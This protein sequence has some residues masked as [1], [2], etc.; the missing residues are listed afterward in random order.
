MGQEREERRPKLITPYF[1][2]HSEKAAY[3]ECVS[4]DI[5]IVSDYTRLNFMQI[6]D[7]EVFDYYGYLHD[8]VVWNCNRTEEG[9]EYLEEAYLH[10]QTEP[11]RENLRKFTGG[12]NGKQ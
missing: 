10:K 6:D 8:A 7:L 4:S 5:K 1:P 11:D 2:E 3:Y 12:K 9:R